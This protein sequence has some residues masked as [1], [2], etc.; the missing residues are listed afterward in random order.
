MR[1]KSIVLSLAAFACFSVGLASACTDDEG[2]FSAFKEGH[3]TQTLMFEA[4]M[5]EDFINVESG[6]TL[7]ATNGAERVDLSDRVTWSPDVSG[8]WTL[9]LTVTSGDNKGT[10]T[11]NLNVVVPPSSW[12]H[13]SGSI[14][15]NYGQTVSFTELLE[16]LDIDVMTPNGWTE[17]IYSVRVGDTIIDFT[18]ED[19]S[20]T[21]ADFDPHYL[22]YGIVTAEGENYKGMT[23][24]NVVEEDPAALLFCEKNGIKAH[25][26]QQLLYR[27]GELSAKLAI[28]SYT[29]SQFRYTNIPYVA[30]EGE[31][32]PDSYVSVDFTGKNIPQT[33]FFCDEIT[34]TIF[35]K[36]QGF[37]IS[38]GTVM[39]DL[40][41]KIAGDHSCLT[42]FGP[43]KMRDKRVHAGGSFGR[44]G[45]MSDPSPASRVGLVDGVHY[46][47]IVGYTN[48]I[49][50]TG[51]AND[52][53]AKRYGQITV[54]MLLINLDTN[55]LVYDLEKVL[56][57]SS[58][59][60][61]LL[62]E[63]FNGSIVLYGNF[64]YTTEWD[65]IRLVQQGVSS[66]YD[67]DPT[68]DFKTSYP[69]YA[70]VGNSVAPTDY[71][72][73]ENLAKG[74]LYYAYNGGEMKPF[75]SAL[76]L[77]AS[78]EYRITFIPDDKS[79]RPNS[80][81]LYV[82]DDL[83][84]DFED[85]VTHAL[86]GSYRAGVY[87]E[88][89]QVVDGN[90]S[91]KIIVGNTLPLNDSIFGVDY[92]YLDKVFAD[93]NVDNVII[94][95]YSSADVLMTAQDGWDSNGNRKAAAGGFT[96]EKNKTT[97]V[98][99]SRARYDS[100]ATNKSR[101]GM[102]VFIVSGGS[103][104]GIPLFNLY[105]DN[106]GSGLV[107]EAPTFVYQESA[108]LSFTFEA[109]VEEFYYAGVKYANGQDGVVIS[110]RTVTVPSALVADKVGK[111]L[112]LAA[113]TKNGYE[114]V[115]QKIIERL[116]TYIISGVAHTS[117]SQ[118]ALSVSGS[119][120]TVKID[121]ADVAFTQADGQLL[122]NKKE[123]IPHAGAEK[124][125]VIE[126]EEDVLSIPITATLCE[127][128]QYE[129]GETLFNA[130]QLENVGEAKVVGTDVITPYSGDSAYQIEL[131]DNGEMHTITIPF[132][133]IDEAFSQPYVNAFML[134]F[135]LSYGGTYM[136]GSTQKKVQ[137]GCD[138]LSGLV[139]S[140]DYDVYAVAEE[141]ANSF[142]KNDN[143]Y[144]LRVAIDYPLYQA[145]KL[146][147]QDYHIYMDGKSHAGSTE[148]LYVDHMAISGTWSAKPNYLDVTAEELTSGT[149]IAGLYG[150]PTEVTVTGSNVD[151]TAKCT[152]NGNSLCLGADVLTYLKDTEYTIVKV[153]TDRGIS[154]NLYVKLI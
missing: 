34:N 92:T 104:T 154:Y 8:E 57:G 73:E 152:V 89:E 106:V 38:H 22:T 16:A 37:Y 143:S 14:S 62:E 24:I 130:L 21:F 149:A 51:D 18:D 44:E 7:I 41:E 122:I 118:I 98:N 146:N 87:L 137:L 141:N 53:N 50:G 94:P 25:D 28:G 55:E 129:E 128:N 35:D 140:P 124:T 69:H 65:N 29:T 110:G 133:L 102:Y 56:K 19:D 112:Q 68:V 139:V 76:A 82:N 144:V 47:Y 45:W 48:A 119:V 93:P 136:D 77:N 72:T 91:A 135:A 138:R 40:T 32:G 1:R 10:Y 100:S 54:H 26:Y 11:T 43:Y 117:A 3:A 75:T 84:L 120:Q 107:T 123:L 78:G 150:T 95:M 153:T 79:L 74:T 39:N 134:Y 85:G 145:L 30:F 142:R 111:N 101:Y 115:N 67:L 83:T 31:Y 88:T 114:V 49:A 131:P 126:T 52:A 132:E 105:V 71:F 13:V 121:G 66:I 15:Y 80:K 59:T 90:Y 6:Y 63:H 109:S 148:Y 81:V 20:Y 99:I 27:N 108:S 127:L 70:V 36:N 2:E 103:E 4:L 17:H 58:D 33:A 86:R 147:E 116:N 23:R 125:L 113:K 97:F 151:V 96:M 5:L 60:G 42:F 64:G 61:V 46:R 9:T 12:S